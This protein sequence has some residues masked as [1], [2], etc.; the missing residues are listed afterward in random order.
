MLMFLVL[1]V[2][3]VLLML[4][5]L[6]MRLMFVFLVLVLM[7]LLAA[8]VRGIHSLAKRFG[9]EHGLLLSARPQNDPTDSTQA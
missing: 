5:M 6:F 1:L 9:V 3:L 4:L 7:G 2:L 8:E